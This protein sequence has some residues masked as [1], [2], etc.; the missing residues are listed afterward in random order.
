MNIDQL[1]ALQPLLA[2]FELTENQLA[3]FRNH[4]GDFSIGAIMW[5]P[6]PH[7]AP[8]KNGYVVVKNNEIIDFVVELLEG[9]LARLRAALKDAGVE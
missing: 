6:P 7:G 8:T 3:T 5:K 4:G 2:E 9:R 1:K